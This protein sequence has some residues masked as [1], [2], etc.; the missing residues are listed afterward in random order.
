[1][2]TTTN[3]IVNSESERKK[4][5]STIASSLGNNS[6]KIAGSVIK[7]KYYKKKLKQQE[8][9]I[10]MLESQMKEIQPIED[11][12]LNDIIIQMKTNVNDF[13]EDVQKNPQPKEIL[14]ASLK[15]DR[16]FYL[17]LFGII[18]FCVYLVLKQFINSN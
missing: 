17:G 8:K 18:V 15:N 2:S 7:T 13:L 1:M 6:L 4:E 10:K 12:K 16:P 9:R 5:I 14:E 11:K 3:D